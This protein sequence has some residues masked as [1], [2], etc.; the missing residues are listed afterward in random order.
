MFDNRQ[1]LIDNARALAQVPSN[2]ELS[3]AVAIVQAAA[4]VAWLSR[5]VPQRKSS[6]LSGDGSSLRL[7]LPAAW[8]ATFSQLEWVEYPVSSTTSRCWLYPTR[9]YTLYPRAGAATHVAF[10]TAPASGTDNVRIAYTALHTATDSATTVGDSLQPACECLLA[11]L[12]AKTMA[13]KTGYTIDPTIEADAVQYRS[14]GAEWAAIYK[15]MVETAGM[16]AGV[17]FNSEALYGPSRQ[18]W[19]RV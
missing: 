3:A 15:N 11:A 14:K 2:S 10:T 12:F 5:Y 17:D 16:L 9:D 7:A 19:V 4:A 13:S 8:E 6:T 18:E 1:E